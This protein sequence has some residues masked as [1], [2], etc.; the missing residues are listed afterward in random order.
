MLTYPHHLRDRSILDSYYKISYKDK[1][2]VKD[3]MSA[4]NKISFH[5][6]FLNDHIKHINSLDYKYGYW[7]LD[8]GCGIGAS[9]SWFRESF[10]NGNCHSVEK[11]EFLKKASY[12]LYENSM[13]DSM[14]GKYH[15]ISCYHVA[16]HLPDINDQLQK[17]YNMLIDDGHFYVA[18]PSWCDTLNSF[19]GSEFNLEYYYAE[20]HI[21][22][23]TITLFES[24][25]SKHGFEIIK[26]DRS[27]YWNSYLCK[28][29]QKKTITSYDNVDGTIRSLE[30]IKFAVRLFQD[31]DYRKALGLWSK[32]PQAFMHI[33]HESFKTKDSF[34]E[35]FETIK[36]EYEL[37]FYDNVAITSLISDYCINNGYYEYAIKYLSNLDRLSSFN[38]NSIVLNIKMHDKM[39]LIEK[40]IKHMNQAL[41]YVRIAKEV[42][43]S[44]MPTLLDTETKAITA[45]SKI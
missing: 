15:F 44:L 43:P 29:G 2:S 25:L 18:V 13:I 14:F 22:S 37:C 45:L 6:H 35:T 30:S 26:T 9:S 20:S 23:W 3:I 10:N 34:K 31:K 7:I 24:L 28:K 32:F 21:N 17:F 40:D 11:S 19:S 38:I 42:Y 27:L 41:K 4:E 39:Y 33:V 1:I 8:F 16:E 5:K 12:L 36:N